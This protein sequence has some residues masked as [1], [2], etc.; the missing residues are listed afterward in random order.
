MGIR[1]SFARITVEQ[2]EQLQQQPIRALASV[3]L[4]KQHQSGEYVFSPLDETNVFDTVYHLTL[5]KSYW[6]LLDIIVKMD[7]EGDPMPTWPLTED[8]P[9]IGDFWMGYSPLYVLVPNAVH[10]FAVSLSTISHDQL[11]RRFQMDFREY[12]DM[13]E[14]EKADVFAGMMACF[15]DLAQLVQSAAAA[16]NAIVWYIS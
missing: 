8:G 2:L 1:Q 7:I 11:S 12:D 6:E 10:A 15:E 5:E 13:D 14:E 16:N 9:T 4:N 3:I